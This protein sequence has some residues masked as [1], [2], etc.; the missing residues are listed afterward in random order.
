MTD[1]ECCYRATALRRRHAHRLVD[2]RQPIVPG[3]GLDGER[4]RQ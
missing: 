1:A 3:A 4:D 2:H